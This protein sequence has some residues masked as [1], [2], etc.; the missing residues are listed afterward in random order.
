[1]NCTLSELG[2]VWAKEWN[3]ASLNWPGVRRG[4]GGEG[5]CE[6]G[7]GTVG[8]ERSKIEV[9]WWGIGV[10]DRSRR[11]SR[12]RRNRNPGEGNCEMG[13]EVSPRVTL[14][15]MGNPR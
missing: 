3:D 4:K 10:G 8:K 2:I 5:G 9:N 15:K 13:S 6:G 7:E 12:N 1:M 14:R 11:G